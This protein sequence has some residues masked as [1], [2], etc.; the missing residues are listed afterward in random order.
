LR[1]A[2]SSSSIV[3][4]MQ[5]ETQS[6]RA[7]VVRGQMAEIGIAGGFQADPNKPIPTSLT[8]RWSGY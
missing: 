1:T 2:S 7:F 3:V 5:T 8:P 4:V 6:Q